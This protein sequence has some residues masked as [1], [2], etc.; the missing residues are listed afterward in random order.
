MS[1]VEESKGGDAA[2]AAIQ[3]WGGEPVSAEESVVLGPKNDM[4]YPPILFEVR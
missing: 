2:S 3:A 4:G 1:G